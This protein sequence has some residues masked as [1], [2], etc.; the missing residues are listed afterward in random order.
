M[1]AKVMMWRELMEYIDQNMEGD[2]VVRL[3]ILAGVI[4]DHDDNL[5]EAS[6]A[7]RI[8]HWAMTDLIEDNELP[9]ISYS[10][11]DEQD[12][13][14]IKPGDWTAEEIEEVYGYEPHEGLADTI[15]EVLDEHWKLAVEDREHGLIVVM[16]YFDETGEWKVMLHTEAELLEIHR[17]S[18][19]EGLRKVEAPA[20]KE[21]LECPKCGGRSLDSTP[22]AEIDDPTRKIGDWWFCTQCDWEHHDMH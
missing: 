5:S 4:G 13:L 17:K 2:D 11:L 22:L 1:N 8:L 16:D 10:R 18:R 6:R 3:D 19:H 15:A 7:K 12:A 14:W 20:W 21:S 9:E